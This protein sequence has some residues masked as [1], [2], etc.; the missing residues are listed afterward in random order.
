M[1]FG[2]VGRQLFGI[3]M[4]ANSDNWICV[5]CNEQSP[6][7]F[8]TCWKCGATKGGEI[9]PTFRIESPSSEERPETHRSL[10]MSIAFMLAWF[11]FCI[12]VI[13]SAFL[14]ENVLP[15]FW[16]KRIAYAGIL[17]LICLLL[18]VLI[19]VISKLYLWLMKYLDDEP[20]FQKPAQP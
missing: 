13:M 2:L 10:S 19:N 14:L 17:L 9:D 12:I 20:D 4:I 3:Q 8:R 7:Q 1:R 6:R 11:L 15:P 5:H 16:T 18:A